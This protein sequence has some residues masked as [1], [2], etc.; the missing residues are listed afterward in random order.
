MMAQTFFTLL[1]I[2]GFG[3]L[4]ATTLAINSFFLVGL[5]LVTGYALGNA[6]DQYQNLICD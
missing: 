6:L 2:G 1:M 5:S 4:S 3:A